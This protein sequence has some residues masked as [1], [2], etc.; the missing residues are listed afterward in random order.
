MLELSLM[1]LH[2]NYEKITNMEFYFS[3]V[4]FLQIYVMN[5]S[6]ASVIN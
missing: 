2:A 5:S 6:L 1:K 3:P 4:S